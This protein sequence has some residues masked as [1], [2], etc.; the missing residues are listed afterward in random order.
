MTA[1]P[2]RVAKFRGKWFLKTIKES[3]LEKVDANYRLMF[4][5]CFH[6]GRP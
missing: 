3:W 6:R 4:V 1:R 2:R 5:L